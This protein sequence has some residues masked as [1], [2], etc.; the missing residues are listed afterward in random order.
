MMSLNQSVGINAPTDL[1]FAYVTD[2]ATMAEWIPPMVQ[3]RDIVGSGE[4]QQFEWTYKLAGL[5]FR[6]QSVVVEHVPNEVSVYQS[7]GAISSTW[8]FRVGSHDG[9]AKFTVDIAY[10]VPV[11]VLGR[12]AERIIVNRDTRNLDLALANV[13]EILEA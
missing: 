2:P 10:D 7:I 4:G 12:L 8:T 13:K 1:V 9:G 3:T 6:G 5:L 11:P